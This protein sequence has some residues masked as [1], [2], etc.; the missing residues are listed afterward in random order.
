[1]KS[2]FTSISMGLFVLSPTSFIASVITLSSQ[3]TQT[4]SWCGVTLFPLH[5]ST[6]F[7]FI[8]FP[9]WADET[10]NDNDLL[11][12]IHSDHSDHFFP[13]NSSSHQ[14]YSPDYA[15][16]SFKRFLPHTMLD[17]QKY[18]WSGSHEY[19]IDRIGCAS[20]RCAGTRYRF[21]LALDDDDFC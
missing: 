7:I 14:S 17:C 15:L 5:P 1:M 3:R 18:L 20:P 4:P 16:P 13:R 2:E 11:F 8:F 9:V 21:P 6:I 19:L 12:L 10:R